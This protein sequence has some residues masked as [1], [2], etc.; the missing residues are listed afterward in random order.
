M[1]RNMLNLIREP[2]AEVLIPADLSEI[3]EDEYEV[4]DVGDTP[5]PDGD[6]HGV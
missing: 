5:V 4:P 1:I 2:E 3:P 6:V